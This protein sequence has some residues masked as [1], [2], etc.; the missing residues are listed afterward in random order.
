MFRKRKANKNNQNDDEAP[1]LK[2][3]SKKITQ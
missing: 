2:K 3:Q 1:I